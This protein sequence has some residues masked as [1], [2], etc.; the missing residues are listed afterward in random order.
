EEQQPM[1]SLPFR[2]TATSTQPPRARP[3]AAPKSC[4]ST[5]WFPAGTPLVLC[6]TPAHCARTR[7]HQSVDDRV[8]VIASGAFAPPA[9]DF[10]PGIR[11]GTEVRETRLPI[12][13]APTARLLP[14]LRTPS[15]VN[16]RS[17]AG[18]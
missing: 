3:Q 8:L 12:P 10:A 15:Q 6:S 4:C 14:H 7:W 5:Y 17:R 2:W 11:P 9:A 1:V 18:V 16:R 13:R